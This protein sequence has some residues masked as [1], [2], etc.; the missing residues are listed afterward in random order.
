MMQSFL[1][2]IG[3]VGTKNQEFGETDNPDQ[4]IEA[5]GDIG[6][7]NQEHGVEANSQEN[8]TE[9]PGAVLGQQRGIDVNPPI[10][11][12]TNHPWKRGV[13]PCQADRS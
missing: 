2:Q 13:P 10:G 7:Q 1:R 6:N 4:G 9:Q 5:E 8:G 3:R 11:I 12:D